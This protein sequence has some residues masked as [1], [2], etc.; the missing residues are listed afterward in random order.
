[1]MQKELGR[2]RLSVFLEKL[3]AIQKKYPPKTHSTLHSTTR[4]SPDKE[5]VIPL[6]TTVLYVEDAENL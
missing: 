4:N 6:K 1:M 3:I 2:D 5:I